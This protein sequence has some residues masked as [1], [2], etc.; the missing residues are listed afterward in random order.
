M[1]QLI[2]NLSDEDLKMKT[3]VQPRVF[4]ILWQGF[5]KDVPRVQAGVP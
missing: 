3:E 2:Y 5:S 4:E 1:A